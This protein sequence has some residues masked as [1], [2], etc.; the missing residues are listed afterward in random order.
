MTGGGGKVDL[1]LLGRFDQSFFVRMTGSFLVFLVAIAVLELGIRYG[2]LRWEFHT[3]GE[4]NARVAAERLAADV[5]TIMLNSGGPVASRTV[6]PILARNFRTAGLRIA[7][8]PSGLTTSSVQAA[9]GFTPRGVPQQ[10]PEGTHHE[11]SVVLRA[12]EFCLRCHGDAQVGEVLGTVTVRDYLDERVADWWTE[13]R[14][15]A[16]LNVLKIVVHTLGLFFLLRTLM[17]PL[18]RLRSAVSRLARGAAGVA[19]RA[20]VR[21]TDEFGSLA[22]DLN[23]FLDRVDHILHDLR[24]TLEKMSGVSAGLATVT[25][26]TRLR[27]SRVETEL[28]LAIPRGEAQGGEAAAL[29][30]LRAALPRLIHEVAGLGRATERAGFL[31]LQLDEVASEGRKL[32]TRL[33]DQD[34]GPIGAGT[35]AQDGKTQEPTSPSAPASG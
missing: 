5:T 17:E 24:S 23:S 1:R 20:E 32:C 19:T 29:H 8:E 6:Y 4:E 22:H 31:E 7:I 14:L 15:T 18:L 11:N 25:G 9:F 3:E 13:V 28:E 26:E 21:S 34:E 33:A 30:H 10:W 2:L 16:T 12:E 35:S 27:L